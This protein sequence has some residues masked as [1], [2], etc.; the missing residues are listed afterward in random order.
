MRILWVFFLTIGFLSVTGQTITVIDETNESPVAN[1]LI[2]GQDLVNNVL[3]DKQ[4]KADISIIEDSVFFVQHPSYHTVAVFKSGLAY[5]DG[6]IQLGRQSIHLNEV[7]IS[8]SKRTERLS[9]VPKEIQSLSQA[10]NQ[11]FAPSNSADMIGSGD[12]VFIQKSQLGGGSPMM[13]GFSAN[14]ILLVVDGVRMNN[15]IFRNGNLQNIILVDPESIERTEIIF[16]PGSVIYGSDALGGV[17]HMNSHDVIFAR[18]SVPV[19]SA[20]IMGRY[21]T[22]AEAYTGGFNVNLGFQKWGVASVF[23]YNDFG[24]LRMGSQDHEEYQRTEYVCPSCGNDRVVQNKNADIQFSTAYRQYNFYNRISYKPSKFWSIKFNVHASTSSDLPRYDRLTEYENGTL[25]YAEW[26]YGP[27]QWLFTSVSAVYA[28]KKALFDRSNLTVSYQ[29]YQES[30][31][32]RRLHQLL[33]TYRQENVNMTTINWDLDKKI[34]A[35]NTLYY[36][37]ESVYNQVE[38]EAYAGRNPD[39]NEAASSTRY[40]DG[41]SSMVDNAAYLSIKREINNKFIF[42]AGLR[43]SV[44][45]LN[46]QFLDTTFYPFP[47][48]EIDLTNAALTGNLG[49]NFNPSDQVQLSSSVS[50]GFRTPNVDDVGKVFDSEPGLVI[51]PNPE[52]SPE[53]AYNFDIGCR[54]STQERFR[55]EANAYYTLLRDAMIRS[56]FQFNNSDSIIYDGELSAVEALVNED[57][58]DIYGVNSMI[59]ASLSRTFAVRANYTILRGEDNQGNALRHVNPDFGAFHVVYKKGKLH[60][61]FFIR[62]SDEILYENLALT[63]RNKPHLYA[64]DDNGNPFSPSWYT[65]NVF[66]NLALNRHIHLQAGI[67]NL[68]DVRYRPY[69]SGVVSPGRNFTFTFRGNI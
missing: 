52:L 24:H 44:H 38:S 47:Y 50:S 57:R 58:A 2:Y 23:T 1:V 55:F 32:S 43:G 63:E 69:S 12:K 16:G 59:E 35:A 3:T 31:Y 15:A 6:K 49:L 22:A 62:Y 18:D 40:P 37:I 51:V 14:R 60:T 46:A 67:E 34:G 36:G 66:A 33:G 19:I 68:Q 9:H 53:F 29:D 56:P 25:K 27:Q 13:R 30:R 20:G 42:S 41:G 17:I 7:V 8:S 61:D 28:K 5:T 4:G 39:L 21:G 26:H 45:L 65:F 64:L 10:E 48:D 54:V 11:L